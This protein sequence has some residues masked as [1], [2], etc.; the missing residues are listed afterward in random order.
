VA[1]AALA[2]TSEQFRK[3]FHRLSPM[4]RRNGNNRLKGLLAITAAIARARR[5]GSLSGQGS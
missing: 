4:A 5:T 2:R 1:L 3:E